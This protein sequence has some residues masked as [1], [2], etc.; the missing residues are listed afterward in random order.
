PF[1]RA[2]AGTSPGIREKAGRQIR[3]A[4]VH[5]EGLPS[6]ARV[7]PAGNGVQ[8]ERQ[9][10]GPLSERTEVGARGFRGAGTSGRREGGAAG[11]IAGGHLPLMRNASD[12]QATSNIQGIRSN[13]ERRTLNAERRSSGRPV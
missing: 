6:P 9:L 3:G 1:S 10:H 5:V 2:S 4:D 8:R 7:R 11:R 12:V 13:A